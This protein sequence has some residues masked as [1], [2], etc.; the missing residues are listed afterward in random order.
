[1]SY[2]SIAGGYALHLEQLHQSGQDGGIALVQTLKDNPDNGLYLITADIAANMPGGKATLLLFII[3]CV[4]FYATTMDSAAYIAASVSSMEINPET[5]P[6]LISRFTWIGILF[7]MTLGAVISGSLDTV[8]SITVI[9]SLPLV[10]IL[11]LM[12]VALTR[13]LK[14]DHGET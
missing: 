7:L 1:M 5:D 8:M 12:C 14:R 10:P 9:G 2:L 13:D 4:I 6:P 3:V 11:I